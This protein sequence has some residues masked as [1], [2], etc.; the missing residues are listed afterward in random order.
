MDFASVAWW[1]YL[2]I[3]PAAIGF[4]VLQSLLMKRAALGDKPKK[5]LFVLKLVLWTVALLIT[6]LIAIPLLLVF[7]V[8]ASATMIIITALLYRKA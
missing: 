7:A 1:A 2:L 5:G 6:A 4:G 3:I 8:V